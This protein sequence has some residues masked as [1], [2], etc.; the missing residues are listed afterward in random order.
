MRGALFNCNN[1]TR[2]RSLWGRAGLRTQKKHSKPPETFLTPFFSPFFPLAGRAFW[3]SSLAAARARGNALEFSH[4]APPPPPP[5]PPPHHKNPLQ[6]QQQQQQQRQTAPV[7]HSHV[8]Q[9]LQATLALA[10]GGE[11]DDPALAEL[12]RRAAL[13][14]GLAVSCGRDRGDRGDR[15]GGGGGDADGGGAPPAS[16]PVVSEALRALED[17]Q[18]RL[19][20]CALLEGLCRA[21]R[22]DALPHVDALLA[23][24][25]SVAAPFFFFFLSRLC[26]LFSS[27]PS[28]FFPLCGR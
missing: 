3:R 7:L 14:A 5:P 16:A 11:G 12:A 2:P 17:P 4:F 8:S 6:Q 28:R 1:P 18:R 19:G 9:V 27:P 22:F 21:G 26:A 20:A 15:G 23:V 10:S 25:R 13:E 24:S